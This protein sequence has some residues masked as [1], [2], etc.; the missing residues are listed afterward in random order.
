MGTRKVLGIA[1]D[2]GLVEQWRG[3]FAP[4]PQ[5]FPI[6][7][8]DPGVAATV[9]VNRAEPTEE[10]VDTFFRYGGSRTWSSARMVCTVPELARSWTYPKTK[11]H[12]HRIIGRDHP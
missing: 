12:R 9:P 7:L 2:D 10:W 6:E 5:P 8:L 4:P 11:L 3:W 1:V